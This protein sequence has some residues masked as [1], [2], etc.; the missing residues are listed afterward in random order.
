MRG[1]LQHIDEPNEGAPKIEVFKAMTQPIT[2]GAGES[3]LDVGSSSEVESTSDFE[4]Q[5]K[6]Y[7]E[8]LGS[9]LNDKK[10]IAIKKHPELIAAYKALEVYEIYFLAGGDWDEVGAIE[11][12]KKMAKTIVSKLVKGGCN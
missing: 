12:K 7:L 6:K 2:K 4:V 9:L 10:T 11:F 3:A 8:L 1:R 5:N